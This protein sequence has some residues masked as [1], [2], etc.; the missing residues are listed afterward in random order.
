MLYISADMFT[1]DGCRSPPPP[2]LKDSVL[3][4]E[5]CN[6]ERSDRSN[7]SAEYRSNADKVLYRVTFSVQHENWKQRTS[8]DLIEWVVG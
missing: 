8:K 3:G 6:W 1:S 4:T 5:N 2:L 7:E